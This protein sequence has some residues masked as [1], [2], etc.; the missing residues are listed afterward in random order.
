MTVQVIISTK[1]IIYQSFIL[2]DYDWILALDINI[3]KN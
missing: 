2:C 3:Y 1:S